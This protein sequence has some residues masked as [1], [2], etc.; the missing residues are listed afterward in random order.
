[1]YIYIYIYIHIYIFMYMHT[2][3]HVYQ[4]ICIHTY[5]HTHTHTHTHTHSH[6]RTYAYTGGT[7]SH[8]GEIR[9]SIL[10]RIQLFA[11]RIRYH[12]V[13]Y[14]HVLFKSRYLRLYA[15]F[16]SRETLECDQIRTYGTIK[17]HENR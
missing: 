8:C 6:I 17:C 12:G 10:Y 13:I 4:Y 14:I 5:I 15:S 11:C 2:C 16:T 3:I 9:Q 7:Y 1:M